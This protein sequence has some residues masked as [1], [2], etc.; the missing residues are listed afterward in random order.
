MS[1]F[2][3]L[4]INNKHDFSLAKRFAQREL[5]KFFITKDNYVRTDEF[6]AIPILLLSKSLLKTN[7]FKR[8]RENCDF[9]KKHLIRF[10]CKNV[11]M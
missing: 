11:C 2:D 5:F 9:F 6:A 1:T 4:R 8:I 7:T 3:W 10:E